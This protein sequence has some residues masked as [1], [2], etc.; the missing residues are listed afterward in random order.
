MKRLVI[1]LGGAGGASAA[2]GSD[3]V[4]GV[5]NFLL[6]DGFIGFKSD[7]QGG[8]SSRGDNESSRVSVTWGERFADDR[9]H[10]LLS[11]V[12]SPSC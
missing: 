9:L 6:D 7:V 11:G 3:A 4:A 1:C 12:S 8:V 2:W 5:V 10:V